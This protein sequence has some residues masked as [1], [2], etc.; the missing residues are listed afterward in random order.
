MPA[1]STK[2][3]QQ[4]V[5]ARQRPRQ[6]GQELFNSGVHPPT[7]YFVRHFYTMGTFSRLNGNLKEHFIYHKYLSFI[8]LSA[9]SR[10]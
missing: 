10:R 4:Q 5:D 3:T 8:Y 9:I 6:T 1:P 7:L 2:L